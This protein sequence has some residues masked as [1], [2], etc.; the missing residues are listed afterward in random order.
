M[1]T[2]IDHGQVWVHGELRPASLLLRGE[3]IAGLLA[4]GEPFGETPDTRLEAAGLWVLPGGVDLHVHLSDGAESFA[5]GSRCAAKGGVTTVMDMAPFHGCV[6]PKQFHQKV[7]AAEAA[8]VVDFGLVAGIVVTEQDLRHLDDLARLGAAYFKVFMPGDPPVGP[9]L[10]WRSVQAAARTG[11]RLGV[12][13]E[14]PGCL[15]DQVDWSHPLGFA[16]SRPRVAESSAATL[17]LEMAAA[18]GAPVHICHVSAR[19]TAELIAAAKARGTDVTA[20]VT[21]HFLLLEEGA[22]AREGARVKTTP[23]LRTSADN[24]ALFEALQEGVIDALASDHFLGSA[25]PP[26][27]E[28]AGMQQASAGIAGLELSLPLLFSHGVMRRRL[29]L[30]RFVEVSAQA[31]ARIAGLA[32]RKGEIAVGMD[33]D[34]NFINPQA[35]WVVAPQGGFSRSAGLPYL[36]WEMHGQ[37]VR[38]MV[39]GRT[40]W[41]GAGITVEDGWGRHQPSSRQ[42]GREQAA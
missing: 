7:H 22:F 19:Q 40:V 17:V 32:D 3:R 34:L 41:D 1:L 39:R 11:L 18:A 29:D 5:L 6:S 27:R 30:R 37:L 14:E 23:P 26:P 21:P 9:G 12:H 38:T 42:A 4:A 28:P 24:Q 20:E 2:R 36:G 8:C 10:L 35:S 31:P 15:E 33:A 16:R 25:K 13:A